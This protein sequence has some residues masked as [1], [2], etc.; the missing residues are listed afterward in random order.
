MREAVEQF[1]SAM[2]SAGLEPPDVI[3]PGK[4]HRSPGIGKRHG[5]KARWCKLFNDGLGGCFGDW[6][7]GLSESWQWKQ[8]K[9]FTVTERAAFKRR[10][11]AEAKA[12]AKAERQAMRAEAATKAAA[13]WNAASPATDDYP[14]L[15]RK[16]IKAHGAV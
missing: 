12:Q 16:R 14:Y 7:S 8:G 10:V 5:N 15:V 4:L 3:E 6:S 2:R 9:S 13:I 11:A 1:K